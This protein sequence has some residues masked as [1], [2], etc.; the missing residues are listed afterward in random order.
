MAQAAVGSASCSALGSDLSEPLLATRAP[1]TVLAAAGS[2][3]S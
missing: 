2:K 3:G 1:Q